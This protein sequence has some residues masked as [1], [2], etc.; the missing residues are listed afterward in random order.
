MQCTTPAARLSALAIALICAATTATAAVG[1]PA[2][3]RANHMQIQIT[4]EIKRTRRCAHKYAY[5]YIL[6]II[7][8]YA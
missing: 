6:Y 3:M 5:M 7:Y 2:D 4:D 8:I 1:A